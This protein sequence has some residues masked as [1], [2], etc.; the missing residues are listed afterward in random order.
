MN[1][2]SSAAEQRKQRQSNAI[3][4]IEIDNISMTQ[5][6]DLFIS[7]S[8]IPFEE[9]ARPFYSTSAN[10]QVIAL[11][12]TD[13]DFKHGL[14]TADQIH[15]DGMPLV[16]F[17]KWFHKQHPLRERIATTDL[18]HE[19]AYKAQLS[20][21]SFYLLGGSE[22]V[23]IGARNAL[24]AR[25]PSLKIVGGHHG[26]FD[27]SNPDDIIADI[28]SKKTDILWVGFG[29]PREQHFV[30]HNIDKLHGVAVVKTCGGLYDFLCGKN[31]RAPQWMQKIGMEWL[32]RLILEPRRLFKR[33]LLTNPIALYAMLRDR[34]R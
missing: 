16:L 2:T 18:I 25:Y 33:Y 17:S 9:R 5:S 1:L 21:Q 3:A 26:Y 10:G 27:H 6:A 22:A 23:N 34:N 15:A 24:Q 19:V 29:V 31:S 28:I 14:A 11:C 4:G 30:E 20:G 32:Y 13:P 8:Q 12:E 7:L